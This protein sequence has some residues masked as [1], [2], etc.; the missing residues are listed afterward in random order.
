MTI[1]ESREG[2][3]SFCGHCGYALTGATESSKCPECG[4]PIVETLRRPSFAR[5]RGR[6]YRSPRRLFGLP[7]VDVANGPHDD[8]PRGRARGFVA[9]GD[10]ARGVIAIGGRAFGGLAI[11]STFDRIVASVARDG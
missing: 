5:P 3:A 10:E 9:I 2:D 7:L 6:R 8:G 4:R 11:A 1:A